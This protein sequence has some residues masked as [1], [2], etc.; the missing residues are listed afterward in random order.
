MVGPE[1]I[2]MGTRMSVE[3]T[4]MLEPPMSMTRTFIGEG[5]RVCRSCLIQKKIGGGGCGV[6]LGICGGILRFSGC[7]V[8]EICGEVVVDCVA[9]M[10]SGRSF[11]RGHNV[12]HLFQL[13]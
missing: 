2:L 9:K 13:Y 12:G 3:A 1:G 4:L 10:A 11:F 6:C 7:F 8:V 5:Y